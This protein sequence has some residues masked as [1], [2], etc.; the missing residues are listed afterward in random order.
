[1]DQA[2]IQQEISI[3]KNMIE[4][5]Q[6]DT[7]ESGLFFILIGTGA[8]IYVLIVTVLELLHKFDIVL[9]AIITLTVI[10]IVASL[11][12]VRKLDK[13]ERVTT[14]FQ[15]INR[16]ILVTCSL[17]MLLTGFVFPLTHVYS[18]QLSPIFAALFF[19]IML[20]A[21]GTILQLDLF[22]WSGGIS[23]LGACVMAYTLDINFPVRAITMIIILISGF[24]VPG[25]ILNSKAKNEGPNNE[26]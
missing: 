3:I 24:I 26:A 13:K 16:I 5:T 1:M 12:I 20:I 11:I 6:K 10:L 14:L 22:Y 15:K 4:K 17:T 21:S 8:L 2:Q 25:F 7:R 23:F 18:W 9:P 19:G